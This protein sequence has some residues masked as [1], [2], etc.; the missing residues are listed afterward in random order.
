VEEFDVLVG[1]EGGLALEEA[2]LD[3]GHVGGAPG[4]DEVFEGV[5]KGGRRWGGYG[6]VDA[7]EDALVSVLEDIFPEELLGSGVEGGEVVECGGEVLLEGVGESLGEAVE[8]VL[9]FWGEVTDVGV[10]VE[11][12]WAEFVG[13]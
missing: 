5:R 4:D 3:A 9:D 11:G 2:A 8:G 10:D 1:L 7:V 12:V 6:A 13:E